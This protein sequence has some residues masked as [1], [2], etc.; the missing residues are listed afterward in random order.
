MKQPAVCALIFLLCSA[1]L[2][3][4]GAEA[5]PEIRVLS[6]DDALF[7]QQQEALEDF[8]KLSQ[9][10]GPVVLPPVDIFTY[11][12]RESDDLFSLNARTGLRYDTI[13]TL[14]GV[15]SK[16]TFNARTRVLISSQEGLF[17]NDPPRGE[18]EEMMLATRLADGKKPE[19]LLIARDGRLSAAYFFPGEAFTPMERSYFLGILFRLPIDKVRITSMYGW[20]QDPFTGREE[21]HTGLDF[22][23]AEGTEV[24][25]ARDGT[26]EEAGR[27]EVLGNYVVLT[28]PGGYQTIY[29]HLSSIRVIISQKVNT[30]TIIGAVGQTGKATG[31]HLHFEV[32]TKAGTTDP[33]Q[34]LA[35]K[36][37]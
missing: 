10:R 6:R 8:R 9:V 31:P 3:F 12:K 1:S 28:H 25:A 29:G 32:R 4:A 17:V 27:N 18:L 7:V 37:G 14:N 13:A 24:H 11:K 23:A 15:T 16:S 30:G 34:L 20:R 19:P 26:V 33:F 35:V 5:Y 36:K 22:A 2:A 21:F